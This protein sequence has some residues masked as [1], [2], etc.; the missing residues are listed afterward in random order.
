MNE[1]VYKIIHYIQQSLYDGRKPDANGNY[2]FSRKDLAEGA[3][4]SLSSVSSNIES[5]VLMLSDDYDF[6][7]WARFSEYTGENLYEGVSYNKGVLSFKRNPVTLA[8]DLN[9]LWALPPINS[10]FSY[11]S[12]DEKHRRRTSGNKM[13]YDAIPWTWDA[14]QYEAE[15]KEARRLIAAHIRGDDAKETDSERSE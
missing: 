8:P 10:L 15:L 5:V 9:F 4:V 1:S 11:D 14:D 12:F 6:N 13:I 3:S 2:C 7:R